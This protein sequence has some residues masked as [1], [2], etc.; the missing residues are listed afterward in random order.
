MGKG[1]RQFAADEY[2]CFN[3]FTFIFSLTDGGAFNSMPAP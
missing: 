3:L 1:L 2:A